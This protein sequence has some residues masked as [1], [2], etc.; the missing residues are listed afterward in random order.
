[1]ITSTYTSRSSPLPITRLHN[2]SP[3]ELDACIAAHRPAIITGLFDGQEATR[4]DLA[5]LQRK[6][7]SRVVQ[8]AKHAEPRL[9]WD[10]KAGL[11]IE[12]H[13][14]DDFVERAFKRKDSG[15]WYLQDDVNSFPQIKDDYRL[16]E[17]IARRNVWR[18]KFWL[19]GAGLITPL[20]YDPV[21]TFHWVIRGS[22]RFVC[23][24][25][26]VRNFYPNDRRSTAP[27]IS[28]VDPDGYDERQFPRFARA[29]PVEFSVEEGELLYLPAFWWHQVYSEGGVNVSLNFVWFASLA[30]CLRHLPQLYANKKHLLLRRKQIRAQAVAAAA[31]VAA[32]KASASAA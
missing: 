17:M 14:F 18:A 21:E 6:L 16:P 4:W 13:T 20:H 24:R 23:Y 27:F 11:R 8:V 9:Y 12:P 10:P 1:M 7:G 25:P 31:E 30:K 28:R 15:Y 2:P 5:S 22:K 3:A 19:S 26:G 32:Q 29:I